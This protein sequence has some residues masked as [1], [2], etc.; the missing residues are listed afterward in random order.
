MDERFAACTRPRGVATA[1][2][3]TVRGLANGDTR[4][5]LT[6]G[7]QLP[8][9]R[10]LAAQL[11]IS[12]ATVTRAYD[13]LV[14]EGYLEARQGAGTFVAAVGLTRQASPQDHTARGALGWLEGADWPAPPRFDFR[15]GSPD[16][17]ELALAL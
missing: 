15:Y 17:D 12:R 5:A 7:T 11:E 14:A 4:R 8:P 6:A 2:P 16:A 13:Q 9:S 1:P 3:A 10:R